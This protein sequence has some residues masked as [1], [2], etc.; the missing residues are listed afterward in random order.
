MPRVLI[1][2]AAG[3]IGMHTSIRFLREGWD[4][5]GIDNINDYYSPNYKRKRL[6]LIE[7]VEKSLLSKFIFFEKDINSE[8]W[9][10]FSEYHFDALIHLAAQAGVRYSIE[11]PRA[12]LT[13]N[14][15]G[16][17][18]VLEF[19]EKKKIKNFL[20]ASSSSVYGKSSRQ[21]FT[22]EQDC[23]HPESYYAATKKTNELMAYAAFKTKDVSSL[24]LR[25]FTVYGP[26]GRPD[27]APFLFA[28]AA[29][30]NGCIQVFNYGRQQRDF[31][32]I[33]DIVEGVYRLAIL[34]DFKGAEVCN[35][36]FGQ[37]SS[38]ET[39]INLIETEM[40]VTL[41]KKY[42][43]AQP[44]DVEIT[45]AS[46]DK[47]KGLIDHVPKISLEHGISQFIDW[48]KSYHDRNN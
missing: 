26:W 47:L 6:Q 27:M 19:V 37:P 13:S 39:F 48:F 20:Y 23:N 10:I 44:G 36:G 29:L 11:N 42:V 30:N 2:G 35:I 8:V 21:P 33:D 1:T 34:K 40:G 31:T 22:E 3:F 4:V 12:Y 15:T 16:F 18:A 38:L 45:Y 5:V 28:Q 43:E 25:F 9:K 24:G 7:Q 17:Q 32:Y 14:I 41:D 46:T